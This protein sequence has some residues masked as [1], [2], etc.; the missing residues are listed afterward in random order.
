MGH[1]IFSLL[2]LSYGV[3]PIGHLGGSLTEVLQHTY[4]NQGIGEGDIQFHSPSYEPP[5]HTNPSQN[6]LQGIPTLAIGNSLQQ[7]SSFE[8]PPGLINTE[9]AKQHLIRSQLPRANHFSPDVFRNRM[10]KN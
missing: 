1:D 9:K 10:E 3:Q 7:P 4:Q 6:F 2:L 5:P 8:G